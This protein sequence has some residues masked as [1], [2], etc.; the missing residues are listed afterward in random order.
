MNKKQLPAVKEE[1]KQSDLMKVEFTPL[2]ATDK[3]KLNA[4]MIREFIAVPT[5]SG[6][7]PSMRDCVRFIMLC[8]GKRANP[9][10]GDCYMIGYDSQNGPSFSIVCG[11]ELFLKRAEQSENYDGCEYG[12]IIEKGGITSERQGVMMMKGET[13]IGGWAKA[14]RKDHKFPIY[15]SVSLEIYDTGRSRWKKDPAG[16]I[17]KVALSQA[18]RESYPTSLGGLYTQEEMQ[19]ITEAGDGVITTKEPIA[20]PRVIEDD[21]ITDQ[22]PEQAPEA[23]Q[24]AQEAAGQAAATEGDPSL[25]LDTPP[26]KTPKNASERET[27]ISK[28]EAT[29]GKDSEALVNEYCLDTEKIKKGQTW[30]NMSDESLKAIL[31]SPSGFLKSVNNHIDRKNS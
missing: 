8:R 22:P 7:M 18:L 19:R 20:P 31:T 4:T 21:E 16:M 12:V 13:L 26:A 10:E 28:I 25:P 1:A 6:A 14:Y 17:A 3:I 24:N 23:T 27:M 11:I 29:F 30:R 15:K 5:A 2:G 9:Y